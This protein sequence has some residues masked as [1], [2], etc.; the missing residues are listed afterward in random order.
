M[1]TL[2]ISDL[3]VG[4]WVRWKGN[5]SKVKAI[6]IWDRVLLRCDA[7][8]PTVRYYDLEPIPITAEKLE[9][10]GFNRPDKKVWADTW[11]WTNKEDTI[12]EL[13]EYKDN[14]YMRIVQLIDGIQKD[15]TC[16]IALHYVHQLQH[17]LRLAGVDKE[18][19]L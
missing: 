15:R 9:K 19:N 8:M 12:V 3:S 1:A 5:I 4:D 6:D 18:I 16:G 13:S 17:A 11:D 2:K 7:L 14:Y 10:N